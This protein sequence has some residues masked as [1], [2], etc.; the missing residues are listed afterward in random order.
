MDRRRRPVDAAG[1]AGDPLP[2]QVPGDHQRAQAVQEVP[3]HPPHHCGLC[4]VDDQLA[5][6]LVIAQEPGAV[7]HRDALLE[8]VLYAQADVLADGA[9][10]LL[11]DGGEDGQYD[12]ALAV[13]R[14]D[15]LLLEH[16]AHVQR[17]QPPHHGQAVQRVPGEAGDGLGEDQVD[18]ARLGVREHAVEAV[19]PGEAR[20]ADPLVGIDAR[21]GPAGMVDDQVVVVGALDRV[22]ALLLLQVGADP[23][24]R[25]HPQVAPRLRRAPGRGLDDPHPAL[26]LR[27]RRHAGVGVPQAQAEVG[28]DEHLPADEGRVVVG[29]VVLGLLPGVGP[30]PVVRV[31]AGLLEQRVAGVGHVGQ[32]GRHRGGLP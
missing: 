32:Y 19:P 30:L 23:A 15:A 26:R 7:D 12:L 17:P 13:Q 18:A 2:A 3:V 31:P 25:R 8:A 14:V 11:G 20:A 28:L 6:H 24:V 1:A 16:H 27:R 4:R 22:G 29:H 5:A 9:A 10:L 21:Q